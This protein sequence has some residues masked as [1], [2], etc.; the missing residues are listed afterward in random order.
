MK[1]CQQ[2]K[3]NGVHKCTRKHVLR[4]RNS[5]AYYAH[6]PRIATN[7][8]QSW[9]PLAQQRRR[10]G[11]SHF[12]WRLLHGR[13][14][15]EP[16]IAEAKLCPVES[17]HMIG[18]RSQ[19]SNSAKLV[20]TLEKL[21]S[22]VQGLLPY[23]TRDV[24]HNPQILRHNTKNVLHSTNGFPCNTKIVITLSYNGCSPLSIISSLKYK[25]GSPQPPRHNKCSL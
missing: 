20:S 8:I 13:G 6:C 12:N 17:R 18:R 11:S 7:A 21:F 23:G 4:I 22:V 2:E 9:G 1:S 10:N 3:D 14:S 25:I 5:A 16:P 15:L 19:V 24:H